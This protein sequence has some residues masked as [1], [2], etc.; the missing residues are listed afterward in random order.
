MTSP[1]ILSEIADYRFDERLEDPKR[2]FARR[3]VLFLQLM[4]ARRQPGDF[5]WLEE[6][7]ETEIT[8]TDE[9]PLGLDTIEQKPSIQLVVSTI[10]NQNIGLDHL[11]YIDFRTGKRVHCDLLSG[12]AS[13]NVHASNEDVAGA[14]G[15]WLMEQIK[16][17]RRNLMRIAVLHHVGHLVSLGPSSPP[18]A[19]V[20]AGSVS[21]SV[22]VSVMAPFYFVERWVVTPK[23]IPFGTAD[24][25]GGGIARTP[26]TPELE[27]LPHVR[28]IKID[29]KLLKPGVVFNR[30]EGFRQ[31]R[32]AKLNPPTLYGRQLE[33]GR[34]L[35]EIRDPQT[36]ITPYTKGEAIVKDE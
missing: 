20:N 36:L 27:D 8:I 19:L 30:E 16:R 13:F 18:G 23:M 14:L 5:R 4:F 6:P 7:S 21:K 25:R 29:A 35:D 3:F 28:E 17:E 32:S 33:V 10:Q 2:W 9:V 31:F 34:R 15:W 26:D 1:S 12:Q 22:M 24:T 11:E